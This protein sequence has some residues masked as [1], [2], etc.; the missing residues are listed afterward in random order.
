[1]YLNAATATKTLIIAAPTVS[2]SVTESVI[3]VTVT[4]ADAEVIEVTA[5]ATEEATANLIFL[6]NMRNNNPNALN[7][8]DVGKKHESNTNAN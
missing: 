6:K 5:K 4:A 1:M 8:K 2:T 3:P 7:H